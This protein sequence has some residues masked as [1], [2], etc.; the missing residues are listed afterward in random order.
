MPPGP[1]WDGLCAFDGGFGSEV[2]R[3]QLRGPTIALGLDNPAY[4][5]W[6]ELDRQT[7]LA[8][9]PRMVAGVVVP[10]TSEFRLFLRGRF[11]EG[12]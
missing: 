5:S 2:R 3:L 6:H 11:G 7:F 1:L 9:G 12:R 10:F 4:R 8:D